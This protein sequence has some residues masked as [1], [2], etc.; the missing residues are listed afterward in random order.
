MARPEGMGRR[1]WEEDLRLRQRN[2]VFPDTVRNQGIFYRSL[3]RSKTPLSTTQRVGMVLVAIPF[4]LGGCA[5][6]AY[7]IGLAFSPKDDPTHWL[8]V[9]LRGG[10]S[11]VSCLF[12]GLMLFRALLPAS[13]PQN[14]IDVPKRQSQI[15]V[16]KVRRRQ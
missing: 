10:V 4:L 3:V 1:Q 13:Q 11:L 2:F 9:I 15:D 8:G 14:Q 6:L 5:G 16:S 12:A 7:S